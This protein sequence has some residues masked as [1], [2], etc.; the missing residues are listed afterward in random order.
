MGYLSVA[1]FDCLSA[2]VTGIGDFIKPVIG[3]VVMRDLRQLGRYLV[4][5]KGHTLK[6]REIRCGQ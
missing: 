3:L 5:M 4:R 2:V 6:E 1:L